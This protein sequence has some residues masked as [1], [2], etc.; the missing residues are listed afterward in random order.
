MGETGGDIWGKGVCVGELNTV[1]ELAENAC[2]MA[3]RA[4]AVSGEGG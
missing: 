2:E 3:E 4:A 1:D